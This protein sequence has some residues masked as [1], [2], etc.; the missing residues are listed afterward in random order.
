MLRQK[1]SLTRI[2]SIL[3]TL[4]LTLGTLLVGCSKKDDSS[5]ASTDTKSEQ[6]KVQSGKLVLWSHWAD[7]NN[8]KDFVSEAVKRFKEK[9]PGFEVEVEW[10]QKDKLITALTTAF[11]ANTAPDI[12]YLEPS[13][14]GGFPPFVESDLMYDISK[15]V[16]KYIADWAM[17]FAKYKDMT[18][19]LPLEAYMPMLYYNKDAF[20]KAGITVPEGGRLTFDELK[21][22]VGKLKAAGYTPFSAGTMDRPWQGSI[23]LESVILRYASKDKWQGI[24]SGK[25]AW[26]DPDVTAAIKYVEDLAKAGAYPSGVASIKLG[27]SHSLFFSGK[28]GMFPMKTFFGGRAFVPVEN[29]GMAKDF[30]LGIM[31]YP[32]GKANNKYSFMQVGGSYGVAKSS[33]YAENAA[34]LLT[35]MATPDMAKLWM[36]KVMGQTGLKFDEASMTEAYF[37]ALNDASKDTTI[38]PGPMELM[39]DATYRDVFYTT[40]SA[41]IAGQITSDNMIKQLE[42]ARAKIKK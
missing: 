40:S 39:M 26:T 31:D 3:L 9:N 5:K 29:G 37:K 21:D 13:I 41:L 24:A 7:E 36:E 22:S 2:I 25:T 16:N 20:K 34:D 28:Y 30:P 4:F 8:K 42:D 32:V 17:P 15:K 14:T 35:Y 6:S 19:L 33:K 1:G 10:Y 12:F 27:D 11:Q 38:L 23:L 18:Y